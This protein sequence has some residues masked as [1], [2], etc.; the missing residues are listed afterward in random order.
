MFAADGEN[1]WILDVRAS[2]RRAGALATAIASVALAAIVF[3]AAARWGPAM[4]AAIASR[5]VPAPWNEA[6]GAAAVGL[7]AWGA[8]WVIATLETRREGRRLWRPEPFGRAAVFGGLAFGFGGFCAV[9]AVASVAGAIA[10]GPSPPMAVSLGPAA[11]GLALTAFQAA[12]EES[13]FRGWMQ[14]ALCAGW[15]PWPG[16]LATALAYAGLHLLLAGTPG[17]LNFVNLFLMGLLFGVLALRSGGLAASFGAHLAWAWTSGGVFGLQPTPFGSV[18][19]LRLRGPVLWSGGLETIN[20]SLATTAV[21][22][23]LLL[24][25]LTMRAAPRAA[26]RA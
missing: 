23:A 2:P 24:T 14:P 5:I 3:F 1:P 12:A 20:G 4:S 21:L 13:Y 15:G 19:A 16:L 17:A 25:L 18:F 22:C 11:L 8:L 26:A 9:T 6:L 10:V 7:V